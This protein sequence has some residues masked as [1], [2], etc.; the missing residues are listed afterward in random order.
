MKFKKLI[1]CEILNFLNE[2]LE[3]SDDRFNFTQKIPK[4]SFY[5]Y[6]SFTSD[7]DVYINEYDIN[8]NWGINFWINRMGIENIGIDIK[9]INGYYLLEYYNRQTDELEQENKK[10][11][12]DIDWKFHIN[13]DNNF[14][15]NDSIYIQ[16]LEFD[17]KTNVCYIIF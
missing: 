4:C 17:F 11:I 5:N 10:N 1:N 3:I 9:N 8:I 15:I 14:K 7:F 6:S 2:G 13:E 12:S 16:E